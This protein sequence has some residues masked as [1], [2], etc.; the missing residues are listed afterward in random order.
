V[1]ARAGVGNV[2]GK[3]AGRCCYQWRLRQLFAAAVDYIVRALTYRRE[4]LRWWTGGPVRRGR[5]S[6]TFTAIVFC[7]ELTRDYEAILPLMLASV[8]AKIVAAALLTRSLMT[9]KLAR[10]GCGRVGTTR[11]RLAR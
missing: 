7:F 10:R 1:V 5:C 3:L 4:R 11:R 2:G 6:A 9:K 8:V